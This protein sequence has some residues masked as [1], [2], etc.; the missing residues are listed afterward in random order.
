M[1]E[2]MGFSHRVLLNSNDDISFQSELLMFFPF[3]WVRDTFFPT[4]LTKFLSPIA[5]ISYLPI[6]AF[7]NE[8]TRVCLSRILYI[9]F[10]FAHQ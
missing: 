3:L 4:L 5:P 9:I 2:Q 1:G 7:N 8:L 10:Y 6:D